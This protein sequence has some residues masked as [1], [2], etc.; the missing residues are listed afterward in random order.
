MKP[1]WGIK[2]FGDWGILKRL[3]LNSGYPSAMSSESNGSGPNGSILDAGR[4]EAE[5]P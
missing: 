4:S 2:E 1:D 5:I 3:I